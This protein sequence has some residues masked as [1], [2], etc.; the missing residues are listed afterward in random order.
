MKTFA[1]MLL[2][3]GVMQAAESASPPSTVLV[4]KG[5]KLGHA[6]WGDAPQSPVSSSNVILIGEKP[7]PFEPIVVRP[8]TT[9]PLPA[10]AP[11]PVVAVTPAPKPAPVIRQDQPIPDG[12]LR[13][14]ANNQILLTRKHSVELASSSDGLRNP[15]GIRIAPASSIT[16]YSMQLQGA[17]AGPK[18]VVIINGQNLVRGERIGIFTLAE[19][20]RDSALLEYDGSFFLLPEGLKVTVRIPKE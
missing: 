17:V 5:A 18:P 15:W 6:Q 2:V 14:D 20:R 19:I 1:A 13:P 11:A 7:L 4:V 8:T 9:L 10:T 12:T 3:C 16:D